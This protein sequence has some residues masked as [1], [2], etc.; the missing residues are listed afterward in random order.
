MPDAVMLFERFCADANRF[1]FFQAVRLVECTHRGLPRVGSSLR[2]RDDAVRFGQEPE[3]IFFPTALRRFVS[4]Q[5][6][7]PKLAVNFFGLLG[8]NGPMPTH[9]TEYVRHRAR[10]AGDPTFARFLD[11]FHHRMASLFYRAWATAQPVV[12][13]DRDDDDRFS[14]YV[15]TVFGLNEAALRNR[16][17]VPDFAKLHFAGLLAGPTRHAA[18]LRIVLSHF[19]GFP[20]EVVQNVGHWMKLPDAALTRVGSRDENARMGVG[21]MLGARVFDRQHKF[22]VVLGPL[23]LGDYERFLPGGASLVRLADWVR[24][25]VRDPLEWDVNLQLRRAQ[26]PRLALGRRLRLGYTTWLHARPAT[27]DAVQLKLRPLAP[28][29]AK[30]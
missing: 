5:D 28:S 21:T 30:D 15:G 22:R 10:H 11:V 9:L 20:V 13:L 19:F 16:D 8:P 7:A 24:L 26:V 17:T 2:P 1:D 3:L 18:G 25:Y 23:S 12:S 29:H 6:T 4:T 14:A 27:A